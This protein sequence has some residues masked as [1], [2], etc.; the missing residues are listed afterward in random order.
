MRRTTIA[1]LAAAGCAMALGLAWALAPRPIDVETAVARIGPFLETIDEDGRTRLRDRYVVSAPLAGRVARVPLRE[2]DAVAADAVVAVIAPMLP[3]MLDARSLREQELR[4]ESAQAQ[5][6]RSEARVAGAR[7]ALEQA[8]LQY[9]RSS[10]L[11]SQGF[12]AASKLDV[13]RLAGEAAQK[14]LD[15]VL[16]E[17]HAAG[18][19]LEQ[20]RAALAAVQ[21]RDAGGARSFQ[22]RSPVS[23]AVLRVLQPSENAVALGTPLLEIGDIE[24]LEVVAELLTT[25]AVRARPGSRVVIE[26]WGGEH[27][28]EGR[29]RLV[30]PGGFTKVSALGVEE[31]RVNVIIDIVSPHAEWRALAD[32]FRVGVRVVTQDEP[33][34]LQVPVSAVFPRIDGKGMAVLR[35]EGGRARMVAVNVVARNGTSAWIGE[36]IRAG[37]TVLVYPPADVRDGSRVK[38]RRV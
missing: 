25:D 29:V 7:V 24:R 28:L 32:G 15:A 16:E 34:V 37:D 17:R 22:V 4:V 19:D 9:M 10:E 35:L 33:R 18:H 5:V 8:R 27:A 21:Q 1:A 12:V 3:T 26:R 13:D 14:D 36:G 6:Q 20:A 31:Q 30:E 38:P 11:S 23:G 2:G